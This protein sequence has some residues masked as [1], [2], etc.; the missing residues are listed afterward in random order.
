MAKPFDS[1]RFALNLYYSSLF[2]QQYET[3]L[4]WYLN[5]DMSLS[6][7]APDQNMLLVVANLI[8]A[9]SPWALPLNVPVSC[10]QRR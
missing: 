1:T 9:A 4:G 7:G 6:C 3:K 2:L 8:D 5:G 10:I